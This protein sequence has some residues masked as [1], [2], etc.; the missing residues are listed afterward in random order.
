ME[1]CV[2]IVVAIQVLSKKCGLSLFFIFIVEAL[3]C[4]FCIHFA[5]TFCI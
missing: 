3:L 5:T 4:Q 1:I 2:R